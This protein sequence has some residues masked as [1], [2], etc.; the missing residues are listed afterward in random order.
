MPNYNAVSVYSMA[1]DS[2]DVLAII[3]AMAALDNEQ[4]LTVAT[5]R[6]GRTYDVPVAVN[7]QGRAP[8]VPAGEYP[9]VLQWQGDQGVQYETETMTSVGGRA[10]FIVW[11]FFHIVKFL[12]FA[13]V[14]ADR[15]ELRAQNAH[16]EDDMFRLFR[17]NQTL[18]IITPQ[19][20][21][22]TINRTIYSAVPYA[23]VTHLGWQWD[24]TI[25]GKY[26]AQNG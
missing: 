5:N 21:K 2:G 22:I 9:F 26:S 12:A 19:C 7:S 14:T 11:K 18:G 20:T 25:T 16:W 6:P 8:N 13:P 4:L 10:G 17:R 23:E 1:G 15:Q 3:D 24:L